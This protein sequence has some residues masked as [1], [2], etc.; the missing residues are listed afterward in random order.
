MTMLKLSSKHSPWN[1]GLTQKCIKKNVKK[2]NVPNGNTNI[3]E[4]S[5]PA[6]TYIIYIFPQTTKYIKKK[7]SGV[8]F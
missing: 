3:F 8:G 2:F 6:V 1:L 7:K 4:I 5:I